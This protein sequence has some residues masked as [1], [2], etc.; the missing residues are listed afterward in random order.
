MATAAQLCM[1]DFKSQELTNIVWAFATVSSGRFRFSP[2][3]VAKVETMGPLDM[4]LFTVLAKA[5]NRWIGDFKAQELANTAWAFAK[6]G[7]YHMHLFTALARMAE[8][9]LA[10]FNP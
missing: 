2:G 10:E 4:Q 9:R 8:Q 1:G 5:A 3:Q 7:W 6:V